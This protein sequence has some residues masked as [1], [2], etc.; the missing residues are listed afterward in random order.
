MSLAVGARLGPYEILASLGVGGM[1]EVWKARDTRLERIVA[2][3]R[4]MAQ[5]SNRFELEARAIAALNHPHICQIHDIGP[6]YLV[7]EYV[8]GRPLQGPLPLDE[9]VR[10]AVQIAGALEAA[11]RRRILHCDLKPANIIVTVER[12]VKLLDFGLAKAMI[13]DDDVTRTMDGAV[14]GTAAYM[15]PEQAEGHPLDARSDIFSFGTVLYE[16]L[17]GSRAFHGA[18]TRQVL[19][20]VL[21][22]DPPMPQAAPAVDRIVRRCLQKRPA[23]RFQT[24]SEVRSAL[25]QSMIKPAEFQ[26]SIAVLPF[27]NL[28]ADKENEY[29]SDGLAEE[30]LNA[31][32]R[33]PGL[34][35]IA[36][37]SSFAFRD[38]DQ[39][40]RR[41]GEAL[42]VRTILEGSVR[43]AGGRIRIT[44]QLIN[45]DDGSHLWSERFDRE[46]TDVFS[47]QDEISQ[48]IVDTLKVKLA[49]R[50]AVSSWQTANVEAYHAYLKGR[51]HLLK[52]TPDDVAISRGYLEK[53]IAID[54]G[55]AAAHARLAHALQVTGFMGWRSPLEVMPLA[56][57]A[58]LEALALDEREPN[59]HFVLAMVAGQFEYDWSEALRQCHLALLCEDVPPDVA[60]VL[61]SLILLPL[62]RV[63]EALSVVQQAR[64]ADP[65]SPFPHQ[66]LAAVLSARGSYNDAIEQLQRL[67]E[68]HENFWPAHFFLGGTLVAMGRVREAV[69][70]LEKAFLLIP[71]YPGIVGLLA[72]CHA[73]SGDRSR[74]ENILATLTAHGSRARGLAIFH[75]VCSEFDQAASYFE[76]AIEERE[77]TVTQIGVLPFFDRFRASA[78]GRALLRKMH[79]PDV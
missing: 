38:K 15:S 77:P 60:S 4:L 47:I 45:A 14:V 55:Y 27:A 1:G 57:A 12:S 8:E 65:L 33:V 16:M 36:R 78:H 25:E 51:H 53:A 64:A 39:D 19:N 79:L 34:R 18:T 48:S 76:Q 62:G 7:L 56:K 66:H 35:V 13:A 37:T 31:L 73:L 43:R 3:K 61:A 11:H 68:L 22:D 58:A 9:A 49:A 50:S 41:I 21:R 54:P 28:S 32:T 42:D 10:L 29:F 26:P 63:D 40:I 23:D 71:T 52:L 30:I 17:S 20:A 67:I 6:D 74:A 69:V 59:A 46:M 75:A 24:M 70:I 72:G 2:I 44:A 5:H